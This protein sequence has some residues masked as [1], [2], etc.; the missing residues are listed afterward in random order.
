VNY[1]HKTVYILGKHSWPTLMYT[2]CSSYEKTEE[3]RDNN[4]GKEES[5]LDTKTTVY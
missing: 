4:C 5:Q 1:K 3:I 2:C